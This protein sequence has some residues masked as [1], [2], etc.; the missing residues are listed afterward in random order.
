MGKWVLGAGAWAGTR[1]ASGAASRVVQALAVHGDLAGVR[2]EH[3]PLWHPAPAP[4]APGRAQG[5]SW[6]ASY[7]LV[8]WSAQCGSRATGGAFLG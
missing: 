3:L 6:G 4:L 2:R 7:G 5:G 1:W 8:Q